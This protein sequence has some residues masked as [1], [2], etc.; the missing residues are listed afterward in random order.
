MGVFTFVADPLRKWDLSEGVRPGKTGRGR[1]LTL[2]QQRF[3]QMDKFIPRTR[4]LPGQIVN[5]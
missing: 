2:N 1:L 3:R 5:F 4:L